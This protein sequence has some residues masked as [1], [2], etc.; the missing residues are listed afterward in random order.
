MTVTD[1]QTTPDTQTTTDT[2][3]APDI[4]TARHTGTTPNPD[5]TTGAL[6]AS[7][8]IYVP[9]SLHPGIAVPMREIALH[10][11]AGEPPLTV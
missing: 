9:G 6:P 2:E 4:P 10:P 3:T 8:K 5:I 11:T 7:R 1:P